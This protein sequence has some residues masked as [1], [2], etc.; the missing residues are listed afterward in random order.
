MTW[1]ICNYQKYAAGG[2]AWEID[3]NTAGTFTLL[4]SGTVD[5]DVYWG[6][7][8]VETVTTN[9]VAHVYP[10][11]GTYTIG[12]VINSGDFYP[13]YND[14]AAGDEII[15]LGDTP[16][17]WSFGTSLL[18]AFRGSANLTTVGNID[19]SAVTS[20]QN[21]WLNCSSL[22]SFPLI[23]TSSVTVFF[24][25]WLGCSSI[26]N[27]TALGEQY[28]FPQ[29]DT[30]TGT[31]FNGAWFGN[32]GLTK[33]PP[34][35]GPL[36]DVSNGTNFNSAWRNCTNLT[37]FPAGFFDSWTGTPVTDCFLNAWANCTSLTATSVENILNSIDTSG[38]SAPVSGRRISIEYNASSGTPNITTA[39]TNLKARNWE[40]LLNGVIQ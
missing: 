21:A 39:V 1:K 15:T 13:Y 8:D 37:D 18:S 38:Q 20:L 6:D 12:I 28:S 5:V 31:S 19:T 24:Q 29:I 9:S 10:S 33:F 2:T 14:N 30:S 40:I 32:S 34:K 26:D 36:M 22:E 11:A 27:I 4:S 3:I 35:S 7:G 25:A 17:G 23:D 16:A